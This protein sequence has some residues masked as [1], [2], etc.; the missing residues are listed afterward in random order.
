MYVLFIFASM[1][2]EN[3]GSLDGVES[4]EIRQNANK[5]TEEAVQ[6][7]QAQQKKA[8]QIQGEIKKDKAANDHLARFLTF[9]LKDIKQDSLVQQIY[10]VFF[11][12]KHPKQDITYVRKTI[13]APLLVWMFAPFYQEK[14]PEFH[15]ETYYQI[16]A[17]VLEVK[18]YVAYLKQLSTSYHDNI[19]IDKKSLLDF[20][21]ELF[22][23]Y[24]LITE[25]GVLQNK[26][27]REERGGKIEKYLY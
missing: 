10:T 7:I 12:V 1:V 23:H 21:V 17:D 18:A 19:P 15:L 22:V 14:L 26:E 24:N 25:P 6:R 4:W 2:N 11:H 5:V 3:L 13:N 27:K 8:Q 20:L 9:L 16:P